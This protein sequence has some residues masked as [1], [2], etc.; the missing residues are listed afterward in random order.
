MNINPNV[1]LFFYPFLRPACYLS[2]GGENPSLFPVVL[3]F[4]EKKSSNSLG[5]PQVAIFPLNLNDICFFIFSGCSVVLVGPLT[6][7]YCLNNLY[8]DVNEWWVS[9]WNGKIMVL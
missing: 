9:S 7:K 3:L 2:P 5:S 8:A 4:L 1:Y 6:K